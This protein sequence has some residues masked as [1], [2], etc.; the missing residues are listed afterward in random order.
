M[1]IHREAGRARTLGRRRFCPPEQAVDQNQ[2]TCSSCSAGV[3][4]PPITLSMLSSQQQAA[5]NKSTAT[6]GINSRGSLLADQNTAQT[7]PLGT[8]L[9]FYSS[10]PCRR[11]GELRI[12][13]SIMDQLIDQTGVSEVITDR[14]VG[15]AGAGWLCFWEVWF[16]SAA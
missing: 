8:S 5:V 2:N 4:L 11:S 6:D 1:Q 13:W 12:S 7:E 3:F 16:W 10:G 9:D 15:P 14:Q